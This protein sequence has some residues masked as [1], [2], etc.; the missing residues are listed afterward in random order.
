VMPFSL[1]FR[2]QEEVVGARNDA[3]GDVREIP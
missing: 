2:Q 1:L 3:D